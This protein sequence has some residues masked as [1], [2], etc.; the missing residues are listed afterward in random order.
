MSRLIALDEGLLRHW[1]MI[2]NAIDHIAMISMHR[3]SS[4]QAPSPWS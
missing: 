4:I 1:R 2:G 3:I